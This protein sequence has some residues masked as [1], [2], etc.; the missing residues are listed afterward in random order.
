MRLR[1][2]LRAGLLTLAL[3]SA[4]A[5]ADP[6]GAAANLFADGRYIAAAE[7]AQRQTNS[8]EALA[9]S[10]RAL[11]A[12]C[13]THSGCDDLAATL[14][15]AERGARQALL[16]DPRSVDARLQLAA[17][18][19]IR[20]R[21]APLTQAFASGYAPRGKRLID[22]ALRMAPDN[23]EALALLGVW[24]LEVLRRGG[25]LGAMIYGA[26]LS[27]GLVAFDRARLLAPDNPTIAL[28][29]AIALLLLDAPRY[30]ARAAQMLAAIQT[31]RPGDAL[32]RH[33]R[34]LA[35]RIEQSLET[36]GPRAA[37]SMAGEA[38][39]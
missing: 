8:A 20:G 37:A 1:A 5:H 11:I 6:P 13:I 4:P 33:S 21:R 19:G 25:G 12:A 24:H 34:E 39:P 38:M 26:N 35:R 9:F 30:R 10:A 36:Q 29:Y 14:E 15:R 28:H 16:L 22:E 17:I 7:L 2:T 3:A 27:Q 23:S 18:S 32:G 31:M